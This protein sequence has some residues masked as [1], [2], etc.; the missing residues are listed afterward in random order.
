MVTHNKTIIPMTTYFQ[1]T[2]YPIVNYVILRRH[3][4]LILRRRKHLFQQKLL[5]NTAQNHKMK[6]DIFRWFCLLRYFSTVRLYNN[7]QIYK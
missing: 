5:S 2:M 7:P 3:G 4:M 6:F 1:L